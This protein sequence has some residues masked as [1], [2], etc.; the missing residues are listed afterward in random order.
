M[1]VYTLSTDNDFNIPYSIY[2]STNNNVN[3]MNISWLTWTILWIARLGNDFWSTSRTVYSTILGC[4]IGAVP[5][6]FHHST[7]TSYTTGWPWGP[8]CVSTIYYKN[9]SGHSMQPSMKSQR[10]RNNINYKAQVLGYIYLFVFRKSNFCN[11]LLL[12][13]TYD[14]NIIQIQLVWDM[15]HSTF[16]FCIR[17]SRYTA[18]ISA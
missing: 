18:Q 7:T 3:L 15:M 10:C 12:S 16:I 9:T 14:C 5:R 11:Q 8:F 13:N 2:Q 1:P 4:R 17:Y 6:L